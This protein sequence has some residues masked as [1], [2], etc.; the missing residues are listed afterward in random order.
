GS[1]LRAP[2]PKDGAVQE[3]VLP[4][5]QLRM[6]AGADFK[7]APDAAE[8]LDAPARRLGDARQDFQKRALAGAV[9][10]DD[11]DRL[12]LLYLAAG[13]VRGRGGRPPLPRFPRRRRRRGPRW[14][15]PRR[16][17]PTTVAAGAAGTSPSP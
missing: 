14:S 17:A 15:A 8:Q 9:A 10:A 6:E 4:S 7:K 13:A 16:P 3:D 1:Q 5:G 2:H 12:S 11:G